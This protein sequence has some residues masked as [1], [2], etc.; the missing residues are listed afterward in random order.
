MKI[1][2]DLTKVNF[3]KGRSGYHIEGIVIHSMVGTQ[4]GSI[5]WFKN[6]DAKASAHYC[7]SKDGDVVQT[8]LDEDFAWHA[9]NV[10]AKP[11]NMPFVLKD[12]WDAGIKNPN[13]YTIGIELE[14]NADVHWNYPEK[15]MTALRDLIKFL[16]EKYNIP[17]KRSHIVLHREVDPA[18]KSDPIG[19][20]S[21]DALMIS[22]GDEK[23]ADCT[24]WKK[25]AEYEQGEKEK[26][27]SEARSGRDTIAAQKSDLEKL[28][29]KYDEIVGLYQS[30]LAGSQ[31]PNTPPEFTKEDYDKLVK[32]NADLDAEVV[33]LG[34]E[35]LANNQNLE[36]AKEIANALSTEV[37][38]L[39]A[40]KFTILESLAFL[41]R[42]LRGG[43][44]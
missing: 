43:A 22:L 44:N 6:P 14:D 11:E 25:K 23:I 1:K 39:T 32:I 42:S 12:N 40:Q 2:Q 30:L 19:N 8:V 35:L 3:T 37:S 10:S 28:T 5:S 9:G 29:K 21:V 36:A 17:L 41:V 7:I 4:A 15:Q 13:F 38:R 16:S 24:E 27:K 33:R 18:R 34:K 31:N 20:F 26:Y